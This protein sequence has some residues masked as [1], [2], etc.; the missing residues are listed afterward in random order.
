[1]SAASTGFLAVAVLL[2]AMALY[3]FKGVPDRLIAVD[4]L[5]AC[6][7][8]ACLLAAARTGHMAFLDVAV[9]FALVAF[10]ATVSWANALGNAKDPT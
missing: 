8:G 2:L 3:R 4:A 10:V 7:L 6:G 9:G 1:M 5:S